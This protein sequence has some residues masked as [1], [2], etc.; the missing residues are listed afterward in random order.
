MYFIKKKVTI[1][2]LEIIN[3]LMNFITSKHK[4][5]QRKNSVY[6]RVINHLVNRISEVLFRGLI[7]Y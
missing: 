7:L 5:N 4:H 2:S 1:K 3:K 6:D